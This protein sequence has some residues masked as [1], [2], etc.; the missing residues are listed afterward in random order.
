M[1]VVFHVDMDT[2]RSIDI[3]LS[4]ITNLFK[5]LGE[6]EKCDICLLMNGPAVNR[7]RKQEDAE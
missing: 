4:N 2:D 5:A 6:D 1:K 3:A 7:L